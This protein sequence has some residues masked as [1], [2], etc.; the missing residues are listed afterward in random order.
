MET[1][2]DK[3]EITYE[4]KEWGT[5]YERIRL[6]F[7]GSFDI[8]FRVDGVQYEAKASLPKGCDPLDAK[9]YAESVAGEYS[10]NKYNKIMRIKFMKGW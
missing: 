8:L 2:F 6:H 3:N 7:D 5:R 10:K 9:W 4:E 1:A